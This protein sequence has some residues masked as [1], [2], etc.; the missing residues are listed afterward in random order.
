MSAISQN[1]MTLAETLSA[2]CRILVALMLRDVRSRYFGNAL[3]A[4]IAIAWPLSHIFVVLAV[5][6]FAGRAAP[7]GDSAALWFATG[8]VPFMAYNY[9]TRFTVFGMVQNRQLLALPIVNVMDIVL[10]RAL[11][12]VLNTGVVVLA[13]AFI[14]TLMGVGFVPNDPVQAFYAM[15][16][17]MLLGFGFG[18]VNAVIAGMFTGWALGVG[19]FCIVMWF[20]S[21]V[22][23]NVDAL[24]EAAQYWLSFNPALQGVVWMRS[25][26][27]EGYGAE[28]LDKSYMLSFALASIFLGLVLERL[29]RGRILR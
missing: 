1:R 4:V 5:N 22:V 14:F 26:Y 8:L 16:A 11:M 6:T 28:I 18:I 9:I 25:A 21:G 2:Q 19:F 27:Y 3:G 20:A 17:S 10:A 24:P 13:T 15:G 12:E 23:I 29:M 7:Y